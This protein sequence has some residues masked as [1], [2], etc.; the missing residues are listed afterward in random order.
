[1][2][3]EERELI[4]SIY[5]WRGDERDGEI[6]GGRMTWT[7]LLVVMVMMISMHGFNLEIVWGL[8][9]T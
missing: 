5:R 8:I 3:E 4:S 1:L 6:D 2:D 7:F 9:S